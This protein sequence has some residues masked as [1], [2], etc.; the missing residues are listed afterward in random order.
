MT[1]AD[2]AAW[3][4]GLGLTQPEAARVL[5]TP[6]GTYRRW[7]QGTRRIPGIVAVATKAQTAPTAQIA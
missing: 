7:E 2:L 6:L 3:R 5:N 4:N 1:P